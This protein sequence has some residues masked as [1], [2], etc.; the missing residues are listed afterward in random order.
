MLND[1]AF[2]NAYVPEP[3]A[4]TSGRKNFFDFAPGARGKAVKC[5]D[6]F[7]RLQKKK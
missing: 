1:S 7:N 3:S 2:N 5:A 6:Q 4:Q